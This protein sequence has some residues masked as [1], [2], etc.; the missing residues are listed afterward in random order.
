MQVCLLLPTRVASCS[1]GSALQSGLQ[2]E[3]RLL[4]CDP[5]CSCIIGWGLLST[6]ECPAPAAAAV[7]KVRAGCSLHLLLAGPASQAYSACVQAYTALLTAAVKGGE[8]DLAVEVYRQMG[9][10]GMTRDRQVF[11]TM[12]DVHVRQG[13]MREALQVRGI[14]VVAVQHEASQQQWSLAVLGTPDQASHFWCK[15][16]GQVQQEASHQQ[17]SLAVLSR[18]GQA[19]RLWC[20]QVGEAFFDAAGLRSPHS[21]CE[22]MALPATAGKLIGRQSAQVLADMAGSE[23]PSEV[24][25]YNVILVACTKLSQPRLALQVYQQCAL[26]ASCLALAATLAGLAAPGLLNPAASLL[27]WG[28]C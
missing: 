16:A 8:S 9:A 1:K 12:V 10:E 27:V 20:K 3:D 25:L 24:P 17:W 7:H 21:C 23:L 22:A 14:F 4:L 6:R 11:A 19:S 13:N 18:P 5:T 28:H 2:H 26:P 15:Q